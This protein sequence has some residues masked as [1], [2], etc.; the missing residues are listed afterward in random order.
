MR[1]QSYCP[2]LLL[3]GAGIVVII[4]FVNFRTYVAEIRCD[5]LN[6]KRMHRW[7]GQKMDVDF[8]WRASEALFVAV[9]LD[10]A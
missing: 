2:Q 8:V 10:W 6:L 7:L 1:L 9:N 3:S 5:R 4:I